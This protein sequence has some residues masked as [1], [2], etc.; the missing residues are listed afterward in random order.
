MFD[1]D[2]A[3]RKGAER[4]KKNIRNDVIVTD[5]LMPNGMDVN[6]LTYEQF[7]YLLNQNGY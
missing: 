3:G 7:M 4:F 5:I 1:G 6:D 2:E